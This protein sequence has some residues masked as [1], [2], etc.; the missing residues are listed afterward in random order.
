[1]SVPRTVR[2]LL[3]AVIA[4]SAASVS[5]SAGAGP[6][7]YGYTGGSDPVRAPDSTDHWHCK[8]EFG[9]HHSYLNSAMQQLD[10]QTVMDRYDAGSC[11]SAT[12]V[13]WV[14]TV[15]GGIDGGATEAKT[16]CVSHVSWGVCDQH[17]VLIDQ[18]S[19]YA[20]AFTDGSSDPGHW[21]AVNIQ[22]TMRH[23]LGHT[24]GLHHSTGSLNSTYQVMNTA[25]VPNSNSSWLTYLAY[26]GLHEDLI[27]DHF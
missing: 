9:I 24:A 8:D 17:W 15:L 22:K 2:L 4:V 11:G 6:T 26:A 3:A 27:D 21:Y 18:P 5:A 7:D 23:E 10:D 1:M 14:K 20:R 12:D 16:V 25:D 13:V 19:I